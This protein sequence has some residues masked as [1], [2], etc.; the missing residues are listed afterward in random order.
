[1]LLISVFVIYFENTFI[2]YIGIIINPIYTYIKAIL[3]YFNAVLSD[4]AFFKIIIAMLSSILPCLLMF[5]GSK[6]KK[7][8]L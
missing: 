2:A 4:T 7:Y 6:F 5:L 3:W 8:K 1:M